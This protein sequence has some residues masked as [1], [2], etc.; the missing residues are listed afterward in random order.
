MWIHSVEPVGIKQGRGSHYTYSSP[1]PCLAFPT[2]PFRALQLSLPSATHPR[3]VLA[4][5]YEAVQVWLM[6]ADKSVDKRP[7]DLARSENPTNFGR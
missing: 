4:A 7:D 1:A 3:C 5:K 2:S 6:D